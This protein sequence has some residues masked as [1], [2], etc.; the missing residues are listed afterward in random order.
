MTKLG[1][2]RRQTSVGAYVTLR[3]TRGEDASGRITELDDA[4]VR[5]DPGRWETF[6]LFEE[7]RWRKNHA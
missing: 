6:V 4:H 7:F 3:L 1:V 5:L 2:F